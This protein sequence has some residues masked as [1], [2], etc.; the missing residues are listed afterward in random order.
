[1]PLAVFALRDCCPLLP[2]PV[3]DRAREWQYC[4]PPDGFGAITRGATLEGVK[5]LS[6]D[7]QKCR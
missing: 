6:E 5:E 3:L 4:V 2:R 1:M 7:K